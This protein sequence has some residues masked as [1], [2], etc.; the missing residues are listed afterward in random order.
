MLLKGEVFSSD[1]QGREYVNLPWVK[2][3]IKEKLGFNPFLGTLNLR[4]QDE[5]IMNELR[6]LEATMV[7]HKKGYCRGKCLKARINKKI[8]GAVVVPDVSHYPNDVL[9]VLAPVNLRKTLGLIDGD[10]IEVTIIPE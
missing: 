3:Q 9:E 6:K 8:E 7:I 2:K 4:V 10:E 1:E 5:S